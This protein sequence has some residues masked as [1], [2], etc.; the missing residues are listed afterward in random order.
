VQTA[1]PSLPDRRLVLS[2]WVYLASHPLVVKLSLALPFSHPSRGSSVQCIDQPISH[3]SHVRSCRPIV[4]WIFTTPQRS[5]HEH[6]FD[7]LRWADRHHLNGRK[8]C[9]GLAARISLLRMLFLSCFPF[10]VFAFLSNY[11]WG[12]EPLSINLQ[13]TSTHPHE[14]TNFLLFLS[15]ILGRLESHRS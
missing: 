10:S 11:R 12:S 14:A 8:A 15:I 6:P 13:R 9:P 4:T 5:I 2:V 3:V 7:F 1:E